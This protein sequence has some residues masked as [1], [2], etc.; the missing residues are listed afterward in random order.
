MSDVSFQNFEEYEDYEIEGRKKSKSDSKTLAIKVILAVL[1]FLLFSEAVIYLFIVPCLNPVKISWRGLAGYSEAEMN[2]VIAPVSKR[3]WI[4]FTKGEVCSLVGT[5][6]GIE[7]VNVVKRFPDRVILTVKERVP[8]AMICVTQGGRTVPVQVDKNGILFPPTAQT[9]SLSLPLISGI[10]VE[11]IP[12]GMRLP[13][14]YRGLIDQIATL[15]ALPQNYFA[16]ISEI[17]VV[18]KEYGNYELVLYPLH[19]QTKVYVDR[20]LNE[21]T[22]KYMMVTIDVVNTLEKDVSV[23]DLRYGSV[24]YYNRQ[25]ERGDGLD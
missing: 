7:S 21:E 9:I 11:H 16:G 25:N 24:V 3:N 1:C 17:H 18:P 15:R 19:S 6:A 14:K 20:Q 4:H 2:T 8:V 12:E 10:P 23:I 13:A 5:V 22:L